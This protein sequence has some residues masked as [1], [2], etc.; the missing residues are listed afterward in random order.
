VETWLPREPLLSESSGAHAD[1]VHGRSTLY[2]PGDLLGALERTTAG[3]LVADAARALYETSGMPTP[4]QVEKARRKLNRMVEAGHAERWCLL[5]VS[6]CQA[7]HDATGPTAHL[8][9]GAVGFVGN[10]L[11]RSTMVGVLR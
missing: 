4:N 6:T 7:S 5:D 2:E 1:H 3:M 8:S 11:P 10:R 9:F